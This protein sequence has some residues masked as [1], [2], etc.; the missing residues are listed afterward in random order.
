MP[1]QD[2]APTTE[3]RFRSG[4]DL[5]FRSQ[6]RIPCRV[7]YCSWRVQDTASKADEAEADG[8]RLERKAEALSKK[9]KAK[10]T[11]GPPHVRR[12]LDNI[13]SS[14]LCRLAVICRSWSR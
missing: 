11:V 9:L 4:G 5:G 8:P 2:I 14:E 12:I 7:V 13:G 3:P 10:E 6:A 1:R